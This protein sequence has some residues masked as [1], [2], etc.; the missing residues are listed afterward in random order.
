M[1]AGWSAVVVGFGEMRPPGD[2]EKTLASGAWRRGS[3]IEMAIAVDHG[4]W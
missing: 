1:G 3:G 4:A 2:A